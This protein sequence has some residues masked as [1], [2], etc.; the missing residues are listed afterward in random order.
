MAE[1]EQHV[2]TIGGA[3]RAPFKDRPLVLRMLLGSKQKV[4]VRKV[5]LLLVVPAVLAVVLLRFAPVIV[6]SLYAFTDWNGLGLFPRW[7]GFSN[8]SEIFHDPETSDAL[9]N[10]IKLAVIFVVLVNLIGLGL[11]LGL[12]RTLKT[13]NLLRAL[14]FLPVVL[15]DLA[16][17]YIWKYIFEYNGP[18]NSVLGS[19]GLG[20]LKQAWT[21]SPTWA[22]Y[23][24]LVVLLWQLSGLMMV[25][26]LAGLETIP[27]ELED[28]AAVDGATAWVRFRKITLP[29]LAPAITIAVTLS[30]VLGLGVFAQV[31]ALTGGGPLFDTQTLATEVYQQTFVNSRFGYGSALALLLTVLVGVITLVQASFLR[32]REAR[33]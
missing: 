23:T 6:G 28:A 9:G 22:L 8:F 32:W 16:T 1:P 15:S 10:T 17:A 31:Y 27:E 30:V 12:R 24:I 5:S 18:F 33:L 14:F 19:V 3:A 25:I 4:G 29:L 20:S 13:R 11:A 26:Y 2:T 21:A 7:V